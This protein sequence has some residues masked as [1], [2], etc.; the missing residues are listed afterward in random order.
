MG[1]GAGQPFAVAI[2][3]PAEMAAC[4]EAAH[5]DALLASLKAFLRSVNDGLDPHEQLDF[6][7]VVSD[8]WTVD[9]GFI[10][11]TMKVKRNI[12]EKTYEPRVDRW[13]A[14]RSP[15]VWDA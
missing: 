14:A 12:I 15:V 11:P 10:T 6:L 9:N 1:A 8:P 13:M 5:R 7:A 3:S 4:R 2:L